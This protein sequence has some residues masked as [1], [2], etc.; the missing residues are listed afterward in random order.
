[1]ITMEN[2][3][4]RGRTVWDRWLLPEDEYIERVRALRAQMEEDGLDGLVT[5]GHSTHPGNFTYLS[6]SVPP[7]GWMG[8]VLGREAGPF[9][10]SGGG[11]REIPWLRTLTWI[12][13]D[14]RTSRSLFTGPATVVVEAL[15][16]FMKP[17]G[18][19]GVVGARED[20]SP[21]A[22]AE[23]IEAL[24]EYEVVEVDDIVTGL[25]AAKRP[26]E[27]AVQRRALEAARASV[28]AALAAW[29]SGASTTA[30]L[31]AAEKE[32]RMQG[33]R[34]ARVLGNLDGEQLAPVEEHGEG[35][36][37]HLVVYVAAEYL[38]YWA[39]ASGDSDDGPAAA[40][41]R[42]AV[43]AMVAAAGPG[44]AAADLVAAAVRELPDGAAD[45]ALSYGLGGG[46]GLD[47][48]EGPVLRRDGDDALEQGGVLALQAFTATGG[49]L[50]GVTEMVRVDAEGVTLL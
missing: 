24:D 38:G 14:I 39:Q 29:E 12:L 43:D 21:A 9:L 20:L 49:R 18:R 42:K 48:A 17:G 45:V 35:R 16:E 50:S 47:L 26:R 40:A 25:R 32:A 27:Q 19:V 41:A 13:D 6:G 7:L 33:C 15:G 37:E 44:V 46:I 23:L 10:V 28:A 2:V 11:S 4:K 22:Y 31:I 3:L 1:M 5:V 8:I 34:D 30:A 36:G